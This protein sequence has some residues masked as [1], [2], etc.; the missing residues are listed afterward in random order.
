VGEQQNDL[1]EIQP[2]ILATFRDYTGRRLAFYRDPEKSLSAILRKDVLLYALRGVRSSDEFVEHAFSAYE[3]SSEETMWGN[4]WQEA[5]AKVAPNT[6]GGGDLRAERDGILWIIQLK[7][8]PQNASSQ[9]QDIRVLQT[10]TRNEIDHHPGRRGV[11]A[12]YAIVRGAPRDDWKHFRSKSPAN[13]DIVGFQYQLMVGLPFLKWV[14]ADFD[15]AAL[16]EGLADST[17]LIASARL[18][19]IAALK[20]RLAATLRANSLGEDMASVMTLAALPT[21]A[22][23]RGRRTKISSRGTD[24]APRS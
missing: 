16:V 8:G 10:K 14:S 6:V 1:R 17:S 23:V 11:K 2:V 7:L 4:A 19:C 12:M 20:S 24:N 18:Q 9:A 13:A 21:P 3:S 15:P 5:I 22:G